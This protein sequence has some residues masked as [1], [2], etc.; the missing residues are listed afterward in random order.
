MVGEGLVTKNYKIKNV[1]LSRNIGTGLKS[2]AQSRE[3]LREIGTPIDKTD[4]PEN[5]VENL[6]IGFATRFKSVTKYW[7][8]FKVDSPNSESTNFTNV[9]FECAYHKIV[10]IQ[11]VNDKNSQNFFSISPLTR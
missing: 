11:T 10:R 4:Y 5:D 3:V 8:R 7:H 9:V 1:V 6:K 2:I